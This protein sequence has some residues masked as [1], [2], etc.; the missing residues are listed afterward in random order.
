MSKSK[1]IVRQAT[2]DDLDEVAALDVACFPIDERIP[3]KPKHLWWIARTREEGHPVGYSGAWHWKPDNALVMHRAG[4]LWSARGN[5]LQLRML[6]A[7]IQYARRNDIPQVWTYTTHDNIHSMNNLIKAGFKTWAP[8]HWWGKTN[9][10]SVADGYGW[11]F[12]AYKIGQE[13]AGGPK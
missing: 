3:V 13:E 2:E 8:E 5:G 1:Y 12:W 6:R 10:M 11:I 4:V 9:P 7:R